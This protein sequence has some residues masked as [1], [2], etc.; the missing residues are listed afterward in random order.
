MGT[1]GTSRRGPR[2]GLA[3][4]LRSAAVGGYRDL[5][6]RFFFALAR[7]WVLLMEPRRTRKQV[8]SLAQR[9]DDDELN[10]LLRV[11]LDEADRVEKDFP[12]AFR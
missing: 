5:A 3:S 7:R 4:E 11:E 2:P 10:R 9:V 1:L 6:T 8:D 12:E